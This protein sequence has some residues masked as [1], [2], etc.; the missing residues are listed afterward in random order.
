MAFCLVSCLRLRLLARRALEAFS[1][2]EGVGKLCICSRTVCLALC[3]L[4]RF[5][6]NFSMLFRRLAQL[7]SSL[8]LGWFSACPVL[9]NK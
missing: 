7:A 2:A 1:L 9:G 4:V 5:A 6:L 3:D 8:V